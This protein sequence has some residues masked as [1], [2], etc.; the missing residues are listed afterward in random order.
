MWAINWIF[1]YA[2]NIPDSTN[3]KHTASKVC[4]VHHAP[5]PKMSPPVKISILHKSMPTA[6]FPYLQLSLESSWENAWKERIY[7]AWRVILKTDYCFLSAQCPDFN[8]VGH[9]GWIALLILSYSTATAGSE[10]A[11]LWGSGSITVLHQSWDANQKEWRNP[12][13]RMCDW[14][15]QTT[16]SMLFTAE[17]PAWF[18]TNKYCKSTG[19]NT[20]ILITV[21]VLK[22]PILTLQG[23]CVAGIDL[24]GA[25][26]EIETVL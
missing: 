5:L 2:K 26:L 25:I 9:S 10:E 4:N 7:E 14:H 16:Q 6:T 1:L 19:F 23:Q 12:S 17:P 15:L 22:Q 18:T 20:R 8:P 13:H 24:D 21:T 11:A 3:A